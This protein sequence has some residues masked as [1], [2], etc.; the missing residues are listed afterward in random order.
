M[1]S[2]WVVGAL[3]TLSGCATVR[4]G[5]VGVK[6]TLG[7]IDDAP[8]APGAQLYNPFVTR[9]LRVPVRT[10]NLEMALDLPSRE[11]LNVRS[12]ISILYR[13]VAEDAPQVL[14]TIGP[15]YED[16]VIL[17]A[18]RSASADVAARYM[19]KDM[20]SGS[21]AAIEQE[22]EAR[23]ED[24]LQARG[25]HVEAVLMKSITLPPGLY[26]AV[27]AKLSAEQDA[28]RMEF[29]LQRERL[30]A[31]RKRIAANGERDAQQAL[32]Q[33]LSPEIIE[34]N[35]IEAFRALAPSRSPT[36]PRSS[37]RPAT[38]TSWSR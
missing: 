32:A 19:A 11:G 1:S 24:T 21:R 10:V 29:V 5:E 9:I 23:M 12:E 26:S 16:A 30:E 13:V 35:R 28:Q 8:I 27:E 38:P 34:W 4:Q 3:A 7:R 37:W 36:T 25:F 31:D 18:F 2:L 15:D 14:A 6:Q 33:S 20:H 22:I 17:T